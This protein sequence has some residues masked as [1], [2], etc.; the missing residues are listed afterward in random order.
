MMQHKKYEFDVETLDFKKTLT[1]GGQNKLLFIDQT[2]LDQ[3]IENMVNCARIN[4][5]FKITA[6]TL[7]TYKETFCYDYYNDKMTEMFE[8]IAYKS[9]DSFADEYFTRLHK[10]MKIAEDLDIFL[11][12]MK[13]F[14]WQ[15]KRRILE[16]S[17]HN[18]IMICLY[19]AQGVGK[20]FLCSAIFGE[21]LGR[22]YNPTISFNNL[23]DERWTRALFTQFLM[24]IE[25][26]DAGGN[27]FTDSN[28]A[29]LKK[30]LTGK[31][32]TYRPMKTNEQKVIPIKAS[33]ISTSNFHIYKV[34]SD[35][36]GMRRFFEFNMGLEKSERMDYEETTWFKDNSHR[37]FSSIN[38]NIEYGYWKV[39]SE[40]GE[41]ITEIQKSYINNSAFKFLTS[42]FVLDESMKLEDGCT[43]SEL[44]ASYDS[45]CVENGIDKRWIKQKENFKQTIIEVFGNS[46]RLVGMRHGGVGAYRLKP[47]GK[48]DTT[49]TVTIKPTYK[50]PFVEGIE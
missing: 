19:G 35:E 36:S 49:P 29:T 10:H 4:S 43:L 5:D 40:V 26:M 48:V 16:I 27:K 31:E 20:S 9:D 39:D 38:E 1:V 6:K 13:H 7:L 15:I 21:V 32:A 18:D 28:L 37:M 22:F 44:Y 33:F 30:Y 12:L 3:N 45:Y 2:E 8:A 25:E 42:K 46:P 41:K 50:S 23:L 14:V 34:I 24:N 47:I 17:T 11:T